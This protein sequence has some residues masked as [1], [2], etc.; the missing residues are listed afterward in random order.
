MAVFEATCSDCGNYFEYYSPIDERDNITCDQCKGTNCKRLV[1][2]TNFRIGNAP[3]P[4]SK[5]QRKSRLIPR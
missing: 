5:P 4:S 2:Y 3:V 1:T